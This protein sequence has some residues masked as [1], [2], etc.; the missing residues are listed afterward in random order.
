MQQD[1]LKPGPN[2][3]KQSQNGMQP[4][5]PSPNTQGNTLAMNGSNF[6]PNQ[7][8][9]N[10]PPNN[11]AILSGSQQVLITKEEEKKKADEEKRRIEKEKVTEFTVPPNLE[12]C[13][14]Y[15]MATTFGFPR[16]IKK[17]FDKFSFLPKDNHKS[18]V[19]STPVNFFAKLGNGYYTYFLYIKLL[20]YLF[21]FPY[22]VLSLF[23]I[24]NYSHGN[25]C[26]DRDESSNMESAFEKMHT[27]RIKTITISGQTDTGVQD[28]EA[29]MKK[30]LQSFLAIKC[31][32]SFADQNCRELINDGC[33]QHMEDSC[34]NKTL[35]F[36]KKEYP[37]TLCRNTFFTKYT[38][39][40]REA[41]EETDMLIDRKKVLGWLTIVA[42]IAII[43]RFHVQHYEMDKELDSRYNTIQDVSSKLINIPI[44]VPD[45]K[46]KI[47][48]AFEK[49]GYIIKQINLVYDVEDFL[50]VQEKYKQIQIKEAKDNFSIEKGLIKV[51]QTEKTRLLNKNVTEKNETRAKIDAFEKKFQEGAAAEFAGAAFISF[52]DS[53]SRDKANAAFRP[54][55]YAYKIFGLN[56]KPTEGDVNKKLEILNA[57]NEPTN[58]YLIECGEPVDILWKNLAYSRWST[59]FRQI[60]AFLLSFFIIL[61]DFVVI[62][63][64]KVW[65]FN[66]AQKYKSKG[67]LIDIMI[68]AFIF[69]VD[70]ILQQILLIV[71][72]WEKR[73][74]LTQ[75]HLK[76]A[77]KVW[78]VQFLASSVV[79]LLVSLNMFNFYGPNGL[80]SAMSTQFLT[81]IFLTPIVEVIGGGDLLR[82][83]RMR[84]LA[85]Q[86]KEN[87]PVVM[88]QTE[89]N[90]I[91]LDR[92]FQMYEKYA[93]ILKNVSMGFFYMP[94][95]PM[96]SVYLII[97][98]II[99][100]WTE[101]YILLRRSNK[102]IM[103]S[104]EISRFM[105]D[106]MEFMLI[107]YC[108]GL[109][110]EQN[111]ARLSR[112]SSPHLS[113]M[114]IFFLIALISIRFSEILRN[115]ATPKV[116]E[117]NDDI[118]YEQ[119]KKEDF[120]DYDIS[121][122]ATASVARLEEGRI[123]VDAAKLY[124]D[125]KIPGEEEYFEEMED[126]FLDVS[127]YYDYDESDYD[128][129]YD[130]EGDDEG[131]EG[132]GGDE[133]GGEGSQGK[134]GG[135][136][137][138]EI[139]EN[140][141]SLVKKKT[142]ENRGTYQ[143]LE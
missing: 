91:H 70:L 10:N 55:G 134:L 110:V 112:L 130:D 115:I 29:D 103:Y 131:D 88:T 21:L 141:P 85:N 25:R 14:D 118:T 79:P 62:Y 71:S 46:N 135:G 42:S 106:Q 6:K 74:N 65:G 17:G 13:R 95:I 37:Q 48:A 32:V 26:L 39:A 54:R 87:K 89:A 97:F 114:D 139:A 124:V 4:S 102:I 75:E 104:G 105:I 133:E 129:D 58:L 138:L 109:Y 2:A 82:R 16:D 121:N 113:V 78:K 28:P 31:L 19:I 80:V 125:K 45:L 116:R 3:P 61:L 35:S 33:L 119:I 53:K 68:S 9:G 8:N 120:N 49:H 56:P 83:L 73:E 81:N 117:D 7:Q 5:Q 11:Q 100:F 122:P 60:L 86:L 59:M 24:Y 126:M 44:G 34:Y 43:Y 96:A 143:K 15:Q 23:D 27:S 66:M 90:E 22:L 63:A 41:P 137:E 111:I 18:E 132:E 36:Y 50:E 51:D 40:N 108:L 92:T 12:V 77:S 101:K 94:L 20:I 142:A 64:L 76:A 127:D 98:L 30:S 38:S 84:S 1:P 47:K 72:K 93:L 140:N 136:V 69:A 107:L 67:F 99:M 123:G 128:I 52:S 57:K